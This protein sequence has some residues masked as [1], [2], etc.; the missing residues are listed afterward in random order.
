MHSKPAWSNFWVEVKLG[1][2]EY[3]E[4]YLRVLYSGIKQIE[5]RLC[6]LAAPHYY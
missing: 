2:A 6:S 3:F 4:M 1:D 5:M